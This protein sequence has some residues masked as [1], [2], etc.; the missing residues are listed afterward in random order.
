MSREQGRQK[1]SG[2]PEAMRCGV[3]VDM[4]KLSE[5]KNRYRKQ[6]RFVIANYSL[7][8][9]PRYIIGRE[10]IGFSKPRIGIEDLKSLRIDKSV[11]FDGKTVRVAEWAKNNIVLEFKKGNGNPDE[12]KIE[13][14]TV[15]PNK[16]ICIMNNSG[17]YDRVSNGYF[18]CWTSWREFL[19]YYFRIRWERWVDDCRAKIIGLPSYYS[20]RAI[21]G[22]WIFRWNWFKAQVSKVFDVD[23]PVK[24]GKKR[25]EYRS[26]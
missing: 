9:F 22:R 18:C 3:I 21:R 24:W 19:Q 14:H 13:K 23:I 20:A 16:P 17:M 7:S 12:E 4:Q 6:P 15:C 1:L 11:K 25:L 26:H 10:Y 8:S 5:K 2:I